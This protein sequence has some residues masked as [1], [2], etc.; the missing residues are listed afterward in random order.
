MTGLWLY[1]ISHWVYHIINTIDKK[2]L[3]LTRHAPE[4]S[5]HHFYISDFSRLHF[6]WIP[7]QNNQVCLFPNLNGPHFVLNAENLR[8]EG[9]DACE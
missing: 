1:Y 5:L 4:Y 9:G 8:C 7:V 6:Q 2:D 3:V